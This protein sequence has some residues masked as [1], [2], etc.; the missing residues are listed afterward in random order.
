MG[1]HEEEMVN[2][3]RH[4]ISISMRVQGA[5]Y[6]AF[7]MALSGTRLN[8]FFQ[9]FLRL[10][11]Y[12]D[13]LVIAGIVYVLIDFV[14]EKTD[15]FD[16]MLSWRKD[17]E[18]R[19][20]YQFWFLCFFPYALCELSD[21]CYVHFVGRSLFRSPYKVYE[22]PTSLTFLLILNAAYPLAKYI[23]AGQRKETKNGEEKPEGAD[24]LAIV[25][26]DLTTSIEL[27]QEP[28]IV[29]EKL[30]EEEIVVFGGGDGK[31]KILKP[32]EIAA[33]I[34]QYGINTIYTFSHETFTCLGTLKAIYAPLNK[35]NFFKA[36]KNAVI[37]RNAVGQVEPRDD[38]GLNIHIHPYYDQPIGIS[39]HE[40]RAFTT[41]Y[42]KPIKSLGKLIMLPL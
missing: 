17:S 13:W 6:A 14:I 16:D 38:G 22:I 26:E 34:Q 21:L 15:S 32:N 39:H 30:V 33:I 4:F 7:F 1:S 10:K 36:N 24:V 3:P 37:H 8:D 9:I 12:I 28:T 41:W 18:K 20:S 23:K 19:L 25:A 11:F 2:K 29:P 31:T 5:I 35:E 27:S 42:T 40:R